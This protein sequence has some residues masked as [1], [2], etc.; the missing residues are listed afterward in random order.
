MVAGFAVSAQVTGTKVIGT[1]YPTLADAFTALNTEGVGAGGAT[2]NIPAGYT[3]TAPAGGYIL[4]NATL[5]PTLSASN[6]LIIRKDGSGA[7]PVITSYTGTGT[8]VLDAFFK[9]AGVDYVTFDGI[10]LQE[11]A[12]NTTDVTQ[13]ERGFLFYNLSATDGPQYNTIQNCVI[14]FPATGGAAGSV[15]ISFAHTNVGG[16]AI[17]PTSVDG[18]SNYNKIY[19]NTV[20]NAKSVGIYM[21][22]YASTSPFTLRDTGNDVGGTSEATGN[23]FNNHGE[24]AYITAYG[25]FG[26]YQANT[27]VSFN[28]VNFA[29]GGLGSVGIYI[30]GD[31]TTFTVNNNNVDA[32]GRLSYYATAANSSTHAGI[33]CLSVNA[34]T[35][36]NLI[37]NNNVFNIEQ[38]AVHTGTS[39]NAPYG[40][41]QGYAATANL[42]YLSAS[43]N[44]IKG[45]GIVNFYGIYNTATSTSTTDNNII[46]NKIH[47]I[48]VSN[49]G[50]ASTVYGV[51][52][53]GTSGVRNILRNKIYNLQSNGTAGAAHGIYVNTNTANGTVNIVNNLIGDLKI[54]ASSSTGVALS[55]IYFAASTLATN[56]NVYYNSIYLNATSSGATFNSSGIYHTYA[57]STT[58]SVLDMRNNIIVNLSTPSG[59]AGRA[60]AFR[61]SAS[62]NLD[63]Y[64]TTSNN[65]DFVVGTGT[66]QVV[67]Y[68]GVT[69]NDYAT[70]AAFKAHVTTR[71]T[72]SLDI[73]PV[74]LSTSGSNANFLKPDTDSPVNK[75]L[76]NKGADISGYTT[77]YAGTTRHATTPDMGAYEFTTPITYTVGTGG[78]FPSLT[79]AGGVFEAINT[80]G[81]NANTTIEIIS[82]LTGETGANPLNAIA[83][84]F[85]VTIKPSGAARVISGTVASNSLIRTVGASNVTIDGS[86]SGG[87]DRSLSITNLST[88]APQVVRFGSVGTTPITNNTLK[89]TIIT[90]GINTSSAVVITGNDGNAGYFNNITVRNNDVRKAYIGVFGNAV[91]SGTNG[92]GTVYAQNKLDNTGADAI[93]IVGL[94]MQG[95]NGGR[96]SENT[97]GNF[98]GTDSEIDAGMW[99]ATG[100]TNTTIERNIIK[101]LNY[102]GTGGYAGQGIK[103]SSATANANIIVKNNF[104]SNLTGDGWAYTGSS[105]TDNPYGIFVF[106]TAQSGIK[107]YNN[108][109]NLYGNT[110]NQTNALSAGIAIDNGSQVEVINNNIVN[111]LGRLGTLGYGSVGIWLRSATAVLT[112]ASNNNYYVNPTG[113]GVK[114]IGQIATTASTTLSAWQTATTKEANSKN[115]NPSFVSATDLHLTASG[116][117]DLNA[118]AIPLADVTDDIDGDARDASTPDIGADEFVPTPLATQGAVKNV[119]NLYPNPVVDIVNINYTSKIDTAEVYNV[120]G[121]KV[122]TKVVNANSGAID[123]SKLPSGVYIIQLIVGKEAKSVKVIKK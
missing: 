61:R 76:D 47:D 40:I 29:P 41:L 56:Y 35:T 89:N 5:N 106:G 31:N 55:G 54:P 39:V 91:V 43:N 59:T 73:N 115:V 62:T 112:A 20:N 23:T 57:N 116:N 1:D 13:M 36:V 120:A 32:P 86:L 93:R 69:S 113:A 58:I 63:N 3:E 64:A 65:N 42:G 22:G 6:P 50:S 21:L 60:S 70:L 88:T 72:N 34:S 118:A 94:Y 107:L 67:Y 92:S 119:I 84:G 12:A 81:I 53:A 82:D 111:N 90:N 48:T 80:A 108:S 49:L 95:I 24:L 28:K 18:L 33:Y 46:N 4:G 114:A 96:I 123:M 110:L 87:T 74:F 75:P 121:Q 77:D 71:E 19:G 98:N 26:T 100:T 11:S 68:N 45:S 85:S 25:F 103:I 66:N 97:I 8:T 104:I 79:N 9:L 14:N 17:T 51:W 78:D 83:G 16:T 38:V 44:D 2:I 105:Y 102:T 117:D 7:N 15:G 27:N 30:Y 109:I 52:F 10:T 99:L 122:M 37:A 101:N